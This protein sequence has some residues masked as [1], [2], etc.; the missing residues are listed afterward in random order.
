MPVKKL[1]LSSLFAALMAV[2][3]WISV[4][5]AVPFTLQ[6]LMVFLALGLLGGKYGTVSVAVYIALGAVG[7]PVFSNFRGGIGMLLGSTG[8]Y[9]IGFLG[10]A[11]LYWLITH[12]FG[13]KTLVLSLAMAG[14]LLVC[15][16]IGTAWFMVVYSASTGPISLMTVLSWCI[17]PFII[18]DALKIALAVFLTQKIGK[19]I[20]IFDNN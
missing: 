14:G 18:P 15:Y 12:F 4:P 5:A 8:G 16:I 3:A 11:V 13:R 20:K 2:G 6:T 17:F 7:L 10:A 1:I 19:H 9:I